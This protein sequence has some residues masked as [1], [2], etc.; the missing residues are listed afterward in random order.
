MSSAI[1]VVRTCKQSPDKILVILR[2][3]SYAVIT[4]VEVNLKL[5]VCQTL[6][7]TKRPIY[8]TYAILRGYVL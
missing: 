3:T 8:V 1:A 5:L 2:C 6:L 4:L 7:T